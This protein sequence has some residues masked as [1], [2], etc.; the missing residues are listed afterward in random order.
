[1]F[2]LFVWMSA[3]WPGCDGSDMEQRDLG[4]ELLMAPVDQAPPDQRGTEFSLRAVSPSHGPSRGGIPVTL[5][6]GEF[7]SDVTVT[8]DGILVDQMRVV[9]ATQ[10]VVVLPPNPGTQRGV[11]VALRSA[12]G[13]VVS[14][15]ELF[16]YYTDRLD[17]AASG[18]I[19]AG[20]SPQCVAIGD[21]NQDNKP[22]LAVANQGSSNVSVILGK[23]DGSFK[24][25]T[26][27]DVGAPASAIAIADL[28][29]DGKMDLA[30]ATEGGTTV[31]RGN[32]DG[33]FQ[34]ARLVNSLSS[35]RSVAVGDANSDGKIDLVMTTGN[36]VQVVLSNGD[37]T[38]RPSVFY[39]TGTS[40]RSAAILDVNGDSKVDLVVANGLSDQVSVLLGNGDGT[41][42]TARN[43]ATGTNPRSVVGLGAC[44]SN[45]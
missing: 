24:A 11:S 19:R 35:P 17:F 39:P 15:S 31:L 8:F 21:V 41:F 34:A 28:D 10:M 36:G 9:S 37:G 29:A 23:G 18:R 7:T 33:S 30:V 5:T 3:G 27:F 12:D 13:R 43:F 45:Q 38:F 44:C 22:D 42:R 4:S 6:G 26:S 40:S 16:S 1:M 20:T 25:S 32:G 2:F 14:R